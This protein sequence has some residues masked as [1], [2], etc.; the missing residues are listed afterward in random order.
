M[1]DQVTR[2]LRRYTQVFGAFTP[3]QKVIAL[4][5]TGA[6]VLA[7]VLVFKWVAQPQYA[8]LYTNLSASDA[9][10]VVDKLDSSGVS[11]KLT[12][13]GSTI[14]VPKDA[15]YKTRITLSGE[16]LP[17]SN[18]GGYGIPGRFGRPLRQTRRLGIRS[19]VPSI[20]LE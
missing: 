18:A 12:N 8:P 7:A 2:S 17:T 19:F 13:D 20:L 9:S 4:L 15:V 16:G 1:K 6:L 11:Y 14:S 5:G 3:A 10:A